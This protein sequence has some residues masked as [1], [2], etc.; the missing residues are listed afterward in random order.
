MCPFAILAAYI[1]L[2]KALLL[3]Y[4]FHNGYWEKFDAAS[5][6]KEFIKLSRC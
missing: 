6:Q 2:T 4:E 5:I 3:S 1:H